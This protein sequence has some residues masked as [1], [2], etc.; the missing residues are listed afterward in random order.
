M[1]KAPVFLAAVV[2]GVFVGTLVE[3]LLAQPI[4]NVLP[5]VERSLAAVH[6][7]GKIVSAFASIGAF[8]FYESRLA[9]K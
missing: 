5:H 7:F 2:V 9:R 4:L 1:K 3:G 8:L 6:M